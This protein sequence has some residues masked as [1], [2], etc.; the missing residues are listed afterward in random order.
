MTVVFFDD[1][2]K[3]RSENS[4]R[5]SRSSVDTNVG[6]SVSDSR[7]NKLLESES[8]VILDISELI[9]HFGCEIFLQERMAVFR[10]NREMQSVSI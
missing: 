10:P 7:C 1:F 5:I 8:S 3:K 2:V 9:E 6:V 4:I